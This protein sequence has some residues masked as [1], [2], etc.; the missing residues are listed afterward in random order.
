MFGEWGLLMQYARDENAGM[1]W[2][3]SGRVSYVCRLEALARE[4][5]GHVCSVVQFG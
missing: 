2:I 4:D 5:F 3:D 1:K